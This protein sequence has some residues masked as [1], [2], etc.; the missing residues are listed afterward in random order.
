MVSTT[1]VQF[2]KGSLL[3]IFS[4]LL[5][6]IILQRG[7]RTAAGGQDGHQFR[8]LGPAN[9]PADLGLKLLDSDAAWEKASFVRSQEP[10]GQIIVWHVERDSQQR[11][12]L[13]ESQ[14][15]MTTKEGT[16]VNGQPLG[17]PPWSGRTPSG[18]YIHSLPGGVTATG[19]LGPLA[20][21]RTLQQ[22]EV[23]L[24]SS[25]KVAGP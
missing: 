3:V 8:S 14:T 6:V 7:F 13:R 9:S 19:P 5:T 10:T 11:I 17:A 18:R 21:F 23:V 25:Q 22:S 24:W 12:T 20:F 4:A 16:V 15:V 2:L 1:Y